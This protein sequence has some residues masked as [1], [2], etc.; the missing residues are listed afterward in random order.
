MSTCLSN[1]QVQMWS[2][3]VYKTSTWPQQ[4]LA[5][6]NKRAINN[7]NVI[8]KQI[9]Y[10]ILYIITRSTS[11]YIQIIE[12]DLYSWEKLLNLLLITFPMHAILPYRWFHLNTY[13][14]YLHK[15]GSLRFPSNRTPL[16]FSLPNGIFPGIQYTLIRIQS[17]WD[18]L[19]TVIEIK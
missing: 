6:C 19:T 15:F 11:I 5:A 16:K 14:S 8:Q 12:L 13:I 4:L 17:M 1:N 9:T 3:F 7:K 18:N 10:D 2:K